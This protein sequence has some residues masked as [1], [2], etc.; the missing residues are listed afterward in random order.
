MIENSFCF[1]SALRFNAIENDTIVKLEKMFIFK[2]LLDSLIALD[3]KIL[4]NLSYVMD[5]A[6]SERSKLNYG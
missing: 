2:Y 3:V 1:C 6:H 5:E 4:T